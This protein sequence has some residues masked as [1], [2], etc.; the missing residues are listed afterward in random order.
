MKEQTGKTLFI[1]V[2][3]CTE[4]KKKM[5]SKRTMKKRLHRERICREKNPPNTEFRIFSNFLYFSHINLSQSN[6]QNGTAC[7]D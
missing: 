3:F 7:I 6:S 5:G 2:I 1:D 4:K